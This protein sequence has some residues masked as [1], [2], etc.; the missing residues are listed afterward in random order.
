V[1]AATEGLPN[2]VER[3]LGHLTREEHGNLPRKGNAFRAALA[4]HIGQANVKMFRHFFLDDFNADRTAAFLVENFAQQTSTTSKLSFLPVSA[5]KEATRIKAPSS[6]RILVRIRVARKLT[7][8]SG[9]SHPSIAPSCA[10]WPAAS[11]HRA[12][13]DRHQPH[14]KRDTSRCSKP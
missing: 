2:G 4:G 3:N 9:R 10:K 5:A 14:S 12:V 6:R 8:S 7:T 11:R 13:A 1:I